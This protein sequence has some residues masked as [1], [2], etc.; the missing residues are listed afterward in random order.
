MIWEADFSARFARSRDGVAAMRPRVQHSRDVVYAI[1][2]L[3]SISN[4]GYILIKLYGIWVQ[5]LLEL[6]RL[7]TTMVGD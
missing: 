7:L 2:C 4:G 6:A 1:Y 5:Y 3:V